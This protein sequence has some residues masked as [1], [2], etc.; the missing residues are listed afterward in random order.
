MHFHYTTCTSWQCAT[1]NWAQS[2]IGHF[3]CRENGAIG[4]DYCSEVQW[5]WK[6]ATVHVLSLLFVQH[7]WCTATKTHQ[8]CWICKKLSYLLYSEAMPICRRHTNTA[9]DAWFHFCFLYFSGLCFG[10]C[11]LKTQP[12]PKDTD[13]CLSK[14]SVQK[15][16]DQHP[17]QRPV[18]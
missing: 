16:I 4:E 1:N 17:R 8:W 10:T 6:S 5:W 12:K 3:A 14:F 9:T 15:T 7:K 13:G 2:E 11:P 18:K